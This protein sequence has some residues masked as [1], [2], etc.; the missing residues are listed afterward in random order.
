L[1]ANAAVKKQGSYYSAKF[2]KL[3]LRTGSKNK[4]KVAIANRM[5]RAIYCILA[6]S[7]IRY[8]ELG[9]QHVVDEQKQIKNLV[10][11]LKSLGVEVNLH[12]HEVIDAKIRVSA[13]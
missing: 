4:A 10:N 11:R 2:A 13:S 12:T 7:E 8:K 3:T 1:A 5:A 9:S 6:G